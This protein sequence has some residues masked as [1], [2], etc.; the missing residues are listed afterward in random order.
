MKLPLFSH[1]R[2]NASK[3]KTRLLVSSLSTVLLVTLATPALAH[4]PFG[5]TTPNNWVQGFLSGVGHPVIGPDHLIFTII[6]GLLATRFKPRWVVP[7]VFLA[8]AAIGTGAHLMMVDL[9]APEFFISLSVLLF[10]GLAAY[11]RRLSMGGVAVLTLLSGL[12]HGYAYG[13]AVIGAEMTPLVS[14]LAGFTVM[15]GAIVGA[16]CWLTQRQLNPARQLAWLRY[17]G[18]IAC[19]AGGAFLSSLVLG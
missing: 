12:F 13:E 19:G 3:I 1:N 9:P 18:L 11:G 2:T 10:G 7:A 14:Y 15:Q 16:A 4:H 8:A 17:S 6:V 5:G